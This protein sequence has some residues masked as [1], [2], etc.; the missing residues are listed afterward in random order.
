MFFGKG[1]IEVDG[2]NYLVR[3]KDRTATVNYIKENKKVIIPKEIKIREIYCRVERIEKGA[4]SDCSLLESVVIPESV[5]SIDDC[6][7]SDCKS[8]TDIV[9]DEENPNYKSVAGNLYS[10]DGKTLI[11]YAI[12]KAEK[13]FIIPDSVTTIS[14]G[15]FENC[16]SLESL[17]I[18][19]S[20]KI[21]GESAF[22]GCDSL[23]TVNYLGTIDEWAEIEFANSS[24]NPLARNKSISFWRASARNVSKRRRSMYFCSRYPGN[25]PTCRLYLNDVLVTDVALSTVKIS[26]YAF[27][28]CL[29][30]T[31]IVIPDS[32]TSIGWSAFECCDSLK[33]VVIP[34]SVTS[35]GK[36]AF[37]KCSSLK[38]VII[39]SNVKKIGEGA[40]ENC[41][42][43]TIYCEISEEGNPYDEEVFWEEEYDFLFKRE[44][45]NGSCPVV[46]DYKPLE[47][48]K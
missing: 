17:T 47:D 16:N 30:L 24:S 3:I 2:I 28:G 26:N 33:S 25:R 18:P 29:S 37:R 7:F 1:I 35:I 12:G 20:V 36:Y 38:S 41:G 40:F 27:S 42:A 15:A 8:L 44:K 10:K 23:L 6:A 5:T 48:K 22:K 45:W 32:V 34:K 11:R 21:I 31:S 9:V 13:S 39:P 46:W 14:S 43:L 19:S 4:F